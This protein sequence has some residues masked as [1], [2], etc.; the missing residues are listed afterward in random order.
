MGYYINK[1]SKG[2]ILPSLG[3]VEALVSD[4]ATIMSQPEYVPEKTVCV[5]NNFIF[6]AAAYA[7]SEQEFIRFIDRD[8]RP[9]TWLLYSH[10]KELAE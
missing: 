4:G 8:V 2:K 1:D 3:K 7:Y 5:V 9:K 10:A 6:E